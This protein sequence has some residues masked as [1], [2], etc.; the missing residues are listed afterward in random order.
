MIPDNAIPGFA[1]LILRYKQLRA[2]LA[3]LVGNQLWSVDKRKTRATHQ[4]AWLKRAC[5]HVGAR[6]PAGYKDG[7]S[8]SLRKGAA[9]SAYAINVTLT[10]IK[11]FGGWSDTSSAVHTYIDPTTLPDA[12]CI[13]L[14]GA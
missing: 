2:Q 12:A 9:S 13:S 5:D 10:K 11:H 8:H 1:Q 3:P 4:T 14:A 6:P 7:T